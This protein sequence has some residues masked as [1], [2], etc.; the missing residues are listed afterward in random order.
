MPPRLSE[1]SYAV[2]D[3]ITHYRELRQLTREEL[4]A[5][6]ADLDHVIDPDNLRG[7]EQHQTGRGCT[8]SGRGGSAYPG[9]DL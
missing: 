5:V 2:A 3:A 1:T 4:C 6:L 9:G 8:S 7:M